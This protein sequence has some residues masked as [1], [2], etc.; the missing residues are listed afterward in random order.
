MLSVIKQAKSALSLLSADEIR[1]QAA[2]SGK[3]EESSDT[4]LALTRA[5]YQIP[6]LLG[7]QP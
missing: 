4:L 2:V 3:S 5:N 7:E 1:K 6:G